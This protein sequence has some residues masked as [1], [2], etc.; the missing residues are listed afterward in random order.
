M[1]DH[2]SVN[3]QATDLV[4][5]L[6]LTPEESTTSRSLNWDGDKMLEKLRGMSGA[7][8]DKA[9]IDNEAKGSV[10]VK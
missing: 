7:A 6:N 2:T 10:T 9:Y 5:K 8:F 1:R 3:K 4:K